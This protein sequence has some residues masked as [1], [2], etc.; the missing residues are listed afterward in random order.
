MRTRLDFDGF[1]G[2][3]EA[4]AGP[5]LYIPFEVPLHCSR[6][7]V[8]YHYTAVRGE[9]TVHGRD[10]AAPGRP[11]IPMRVLALASGLL[12][13]T[14]AVACGSNA[15]SPDE[16]SRRPEAQLAF[17]SALPI[18]TR[19][20]PFDSGGILS[21]DVLASWEVT[22]RTN[23]TV[24]EVY[25]FYS[26]RLSGMGWVETPTG[27]GSLD[28]KDYT[29]LKDD[30]QLHLEFLDGRVDITPVNDGFNLSYR[31]VLISTSH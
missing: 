30:F 20:V 7:D 11:R 5:Y 14:L 21:P 13:M 22:S 28:L 9:E 31:V 2:A 17:P 29:W 25:N 10:P 3:A 24:D 19:S 26:Q 18:A 12:L 1:V 27:T 16:L 8:S 4:A 6:L 23:A 15:P